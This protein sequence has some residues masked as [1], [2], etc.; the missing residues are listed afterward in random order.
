MTR[1]AYIV[2]LV[3]KAVAF[4]WIVQHIDHT[5]LELTFILLH[6]EETSLEKNLKAE[7][8]PVFRVHYSGKKDVPSAIL[9]VRRLLRK[10]KIDV[11]HAH[12]FDASIV[13]LTAAKLAG[14]K[15]RIHTRHNATIH[16]DYHPHAVKYDRYINYLSTHIVAISQNVKTILTDLE[17]V[18]PEKISIIHHGFMLEQFSAIPQARVE[19]LRQKY[20]PGE[21]L[22]IG[23]ISRYIHWKGI[24]HILPAFK[25]LLAD[26]QQVK[27]VLANA[28]GPYQAEVKSMLAELPADRYLEIL[29][30]EDIF[31]L[32][33]LFD[34]FV[35]VPIDSRS[36]A[37][38]QIYVEALAAGV[39]SVFTLSGIANDFIRDRQN[40]LVVPFN[41][42]EAIYGA[43]T[44]LLEND[45]LRETLVRN[46]KKDVQ[47]LFTLD[48]MI[49]SLEALYE[50]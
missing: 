8:I 46:G 20:I 5:K 12:L 29:F 45:E 15:N 42:S 23:V 3:N 44:E 34:V 27:L 26:H 38:G 13:G 7:N 16:H 22:V 33:P 31:A 39:P 50:K 40:A 49:R 2:S 24:Q 19:V 10:N 32:Y 17:N 14:I 25:Q 4:E 11:V 9:K 35:H 48:K 37:F 6:S 18:N 30:E 47:E 21:T 43:V 41:D 36:E 1:V 28:T